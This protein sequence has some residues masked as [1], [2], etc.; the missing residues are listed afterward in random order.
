MKNTIHIKDSSFE[1]REN[2]L[3]NWV[4]ALPIIPEDDDEYEYDFKDDPC[5]LHR[6]QIERIKR[7]PEL[8]PILK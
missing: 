8:D 6:V 2:I 1:T 7:V 5:Q 3:R 4:D